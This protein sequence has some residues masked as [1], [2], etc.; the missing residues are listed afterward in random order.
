[1]EQQVSPQLQRAMDMVN[2]YVE[3]IGLTIDQAYR[4]DTRSWHWKMG[5]ASMEVFFTVLTF[6]GGSSRTYLRIFSKL[7]EVPTNNVVQFYRHLLEL[8]DT[9]LGVKISVQPNSQNVYATYERDI[10][11]MDYNEI[12]IV[13]ADMEYWAD[14]LDDELKTQFPA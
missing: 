1:M 11:G 10:R 9:K 7:M 13:I 5:S 2:Q 12:S 4:P 6:E 14:R 8:N 3:Y